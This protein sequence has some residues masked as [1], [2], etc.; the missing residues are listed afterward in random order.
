MPAASARR[1]WRICRLKS[2][3]HL[4][5]GVELERLD[6]QHHRQS[7]RVEP[8]A[9]SRP[10]RAVTPSRS[11]SR[12]SAFPR[13]PRPVLDPSRRADRCDRHHRAVVPAAGR[14]AACLR[15]RRD[16]GRAPHLRAII[17]E[18]AMSLAVKPRPLGPDR[19]DVRCV[20]PASTFLG[21][22]PHWS[23]GQRSSISSISWR[24]P[25]AYRRSGQ[26]H[27]H[28]SMQVPEL[29]SFI[30]AAQAR[31]FR[32][33]HARRN[34]RHRS[35]EAATSPRLREPEADRPGQPLQRRQMRPARTALGRHARHRY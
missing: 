13:S 19:A 5:D 17:G 11:T 31:R 3:A 29:I 34:S 33:R 12:I 8:P 2:A 6:A 26:G 35:F 16:R 27:L 1:F 18:F 7:G 25:V 28:R 20:I 30:V 14:P 22:G 32:R 9:R 15:P 24:L 10:R 4:L 21:E 23:P